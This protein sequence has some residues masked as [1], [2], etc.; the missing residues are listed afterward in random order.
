MYSNILLKEEK[1]NIGRNRECLVIIDS[2]IV[3]NFHAIIERKPDGKVI[4]IDDR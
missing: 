2:A 1:F 4:I 3:S